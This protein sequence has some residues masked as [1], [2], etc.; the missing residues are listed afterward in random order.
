MK[1]GSSK[2]LAAAQHPAQSLEAARA[3]LTASKRMS[4]YRAELHRRK[5][6]SVTTR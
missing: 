2:L 1:E 4:A 6:E 5:T 3:L